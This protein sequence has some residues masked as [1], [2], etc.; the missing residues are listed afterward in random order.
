[1]SLHMEQLFAIGI[2][3]LAHCSSYA[4]MKSAINGRTFTYNYE[5]TDQMKIWLTKI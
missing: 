3:L 1:M 4:L 5:V 2:E